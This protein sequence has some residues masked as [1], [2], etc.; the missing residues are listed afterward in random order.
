MQQVPVCARADLVLSTKVGPLTGMGN[1]LFPRSTIFFFLFYFFSY[2]SELASFHSLSFTWQVSL[3]QQPRLWHNS[4][5]HSLQEP[6]FLST[7]YGLFPL[8]KTGGSFFILLLCF[9]FRQYHSVD[10]F[11]YLWQDFFLSQNGLSQVIYSIN[12]FQPH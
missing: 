8:E 6:L 1:L 11:S 10:R 5:G 7:L 12:I 3:V 9:A 2:L 4:W